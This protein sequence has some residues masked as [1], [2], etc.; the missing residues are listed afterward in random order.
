MTLETYEL[1]TLY[2]RLIPDRRRKDKPFSEDIKKVNDLLFPRYYT[3]SEKHEFLRKWLHKE[4]PCVFGSVAAAVSELYFCL[5]DDLELRTKSDQAI[6]TKIK[7][8]LLEWKRQS[9]DP[10]IPTPAH[11]FVLLVYSRDIADAT[12]DE[13]LFNFACK[14][15]DLWGSVSSVEP[16]GPMHWETLYLRQPGTQSYL[17]F[18]FSIDYFG[19]QGDGEWWHDHR[20]PGGIMFTANAVGYMKKYREWYRKLGNQDDWVLQLAMLTIANA[21]DTEVGPAT[22]LRPLGKDGHP[23]IETLKCPFSNSERVKDTIKDMD[24]TKYFGRLHTDH[25]VRREF[26]EFGDHSEEHQTWQ[27]IE[28]FT[29]LYDQS[30]TDYERFVAGTIVD[31]SEIDEMLGPISTWQRIAGRVARSPIPRRVIGAVADLTAPVRRQE[32]ISR[33]ERRRLHAIADEVLAWEGKWDHV[34]DVA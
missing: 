1:R 22:W 19:A 6:A 23:M 33:E 10:S 17:K 20:C 12:N 25:S 32:R 7:D 34:M 30:S 8:E 27:H 21:K 24:W 26:F 18:T 16:S 9:V 29:Y 4:Q 15:R 13:N 5:I 2:E 14:V 28:D 11:G 31:Q 3:L